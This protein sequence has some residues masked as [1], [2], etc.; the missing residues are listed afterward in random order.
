MMGRMVDVLRGGLA[1]T[2]WAAVIAAQAQ[3]RLRGPEHA[4]VVVAGDAATATGHL[5]AGNARTATPLPVGECALHFAVGAHGK[6]GSLALTVADG[7]DVLVAADG[8]GSSADRRIDLGATAAWQSVDGGRIAIGAPLRASRCTA[9]VGVGSDACALVARWS[10]AENNY[11]FV[12]DR[13]RHELRL[14]RRMGDLR[15]LAQGPAPADGGEHELVLQVDGFRL[16]AFF[17]DV[18]VLAALDGALIEGGVGVLGAGPWQQFAV[19]APAAPAASAALV[20]RPGSARYHAFVNVSPGHLYVVELAL[21]RPGPA[22]VPGLD[23][24]ALQLLGP[25]PLPGILRGDWRMSLG[26]NAIG[27]VGVNGR[28]AAEIRW[29]EVPRLVG[30]GVLVRAALVSANGEVV[31]GWSP[32][33]DLPLRR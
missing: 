28:F 14:E 23:G 13:P 11:R 3:W 10:D 2:L 12:W 26:P 16:A 15:V 31:A 29:P 33:V 22:R 18:P 30:E 21:D 19:G 7:D 8:A 4:H 32:A 27:E 25:P 1:V 17:D 24:D 9:R 5:L 6:P 20:V